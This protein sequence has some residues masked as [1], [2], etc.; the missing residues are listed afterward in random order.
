M[1][2]SQRAW[3][4]ST[5]QPTGVNENALNMQAGTNPPP[6]PMTQ[7]VTVNTETV[8]NNPA[9]TSETPATPLYVSIPPNS[10]TEKL[11]FDLFISGSITTGGD[12][13]AT[14]KLYGDAVPTGTPGD[15]T[16]VATSGAVTINDTTEPFWLQ[17]K[18]VYD[19]VSGKMR[20]QYSGQVGNTAVAAT[21]L[22]ASPTG[23]ENSNDPVI[24]FYPTITFGTANAGN[25]IL[26]E[27]FSV[28]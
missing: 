10:P 26:V 15:D 5:G 13:T 27:A 14:L 3:G 25:S 1:P 19:T 21:T 28:G 11:E 22:T 18:L 6:V 12:Y 20:G 16:A 8:I 4:P 7:A 2:N 24:S 9:L 17:L 23:I